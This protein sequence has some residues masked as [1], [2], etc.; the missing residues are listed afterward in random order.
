V[1]TRDTPSTRAERSYG[2]KPV[3][4]SD[5]KVWKLAV[6]FLVGITTLWK[7]VG[8]VSA[9]SS[10]RWNPG[11]FAETLRVPIWMTPVMTAGGSRRPGKI[12]AA[13][14]QIFGRG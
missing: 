9:E 1:F 11:E 12:A 13:S 2:A 4:R 6:R 10:W 8:G 3:S 14:D 7:I 5:P